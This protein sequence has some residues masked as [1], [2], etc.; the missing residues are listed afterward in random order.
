MIAHPTLPRDRNPPAFR[1][2]VQEDSRSVVLESLLRIANSSVSETLA[3]ACAIL[4]LF[5]LPSAFRS[6]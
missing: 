3:I 4:S 6:I 2:P 1:H 5:D